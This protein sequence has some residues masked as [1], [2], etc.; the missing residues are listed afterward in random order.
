MNIIRIFFEFLPLLL[1]FIGVLIIVRGHRRLA[2]MT[3]AERRLHLEGENRWL[4]ALDDPS[5]PRS[6]GGTGIRHDDD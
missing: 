5:L 4:P 1:L 2:R 6:C 3:A